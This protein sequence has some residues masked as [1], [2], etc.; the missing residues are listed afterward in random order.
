MTEILFVSRARRRGRVHE[1]LKEKIECDSFL[2]SRRNI[3]GCGSEEKF[4]PTRVAM[5]AIY[6]LLVLN[7]MIPINVP[8]GPVIQTT[9]IADELLFYTSH[10]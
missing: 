3:Y 5:Y 9:L 4:L 8:G 10:L 1:R 2:L 7:I 6:S